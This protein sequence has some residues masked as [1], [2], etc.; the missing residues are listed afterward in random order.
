M[1]ILSRVEQLRADAHAVARALHLAFDDVGNAK[2]VRDLAKI[3]CSAALVLHHACPADDFQLGHLRQISENLILHT[4]REI[5]VLL[6]LAQIL[7]RQHSDAF[8]WRRLNYRRP[9]SRK[10]NDTD[11]KSRDSNEPG[12]P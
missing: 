8:V 10:Y 1:N 9:I 5:G 6:L 4:I 11:Q 2:L 12:C 3:T 7:K